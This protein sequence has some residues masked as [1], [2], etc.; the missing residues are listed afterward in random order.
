MKSAIC[1]TSTLYYTRLPAQINP[2]KSFYAST[3]WL[4]SMLPAVL[5]DELPPVVW[6]FSCCPEISQKTLD[7]HAK[8]DTIIHCPFRLRRTSW[9]PVKR[10]VG[11]P[12]T[13][14]GTGE[15]TPDSEA[16]R[17]VAG[18]IGYRWQ[19]VCRVSPYRVR[20]LLRR[21]VAQGAD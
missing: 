14:V 15:R 10:N 1:R 21:P 3:G 18:T 4:K 12:K 9:R 20:S 5:W 7:N 13:T 19:G 2:M 11:W 16:I 8:S 17:A 6:I